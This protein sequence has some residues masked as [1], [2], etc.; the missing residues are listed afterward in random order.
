MTNGYH[1]STK[2]KKAAKKDKKA[3]RVPPRTKE[4]P[5]KGAVDRK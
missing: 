2:P 3:K 4:E 1:K 5:A